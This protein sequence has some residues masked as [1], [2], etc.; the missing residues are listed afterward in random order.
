M[1]AVAFLLF[2]AI[3]VGYGARLLDQTLAILI[4]GLYIAGSVVLVLKA[5]GSGPGDRRKI[6]SCG[7]LAL[8][9]DSW[10]QW[11]L[12]EKERPARR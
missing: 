4:L 2:V 3:G 1:L 5:L 12:D 8:L 10:R 7:E 11:L 9:P 6:F